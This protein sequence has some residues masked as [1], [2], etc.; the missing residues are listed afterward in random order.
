MLDCR[1]TTVSAVVVE[2][3]AFHYIDANVTTT[4][5]P[6][7][8]IIGFDIVGIGVVDFGKG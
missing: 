3:L 4:L 8:C 6:G 2:L 5:R 7:G 1:H